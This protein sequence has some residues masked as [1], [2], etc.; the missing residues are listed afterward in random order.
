VTG[1]PSNQRNFAPV[2]FLLAG[3]T[4]AL[5]IAQLVKGLS[6]LAVVADFVIAGVMIAMGIKVMKP[7]T[8]PKTPR[9]L[10]VPRPPR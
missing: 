2:F 1:T 7:P 10:R 8:P 5:G 3:I 9:P 6:L 4:V